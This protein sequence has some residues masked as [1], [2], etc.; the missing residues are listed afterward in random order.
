MRVHVEGGGAVELP[1]ESFVAAGGEA[2]VYAVGDVAYKV[3]TRPTDEAR[4]RALLRLKVASA[5]LPLALLRDEH[6]AVIG[7]T[8][9]FVT[10]GTPLSRALSRTWRERSGL[11]PDEA[12]DV[13][14]Q[15]RDAVQ[16]VHRAGALVVD[17]HEGNVVL[18]P[19]RSPLLLDTSSWQL[20][21][22]PATAIQDAVRDRHATAFDRGTDWFA[23]AVTTLHLLLGIHPYRGTHPTVK[24]L[25]ARMVHRLSVLRPEVK[26]P[27]VCFPL[28]V[29]P[30]PWRSWY[31]SVLDGP[32]RTPPPSGGID[33]VGWFPTVV[34]TRGQLVLT[35]VLEAPGPILTALE[36]EGTTVAHQADGVNVGST[37]HAGRYEAVGIAADG[38]VLGARRSAGPLSVWVVATGRELPTTLRADAVAPFGPGLLVTS[39]P[40]LLQLELRAGVLVPRLLSAVLPHATAVFGSVAVQDLLGAAHLLL[41]APGRCDVRRVPEL[42]G[43]KMLDAHHARGVVALHARKDGRTDRFVFRFGPSAHDLRRT[44]DVEGADLDLVALPSGVA[45]LRV[46]GRLELF[47]AGPGDDDLRLIEDPA[48]VGTRLLTL[49]GQLGLVSGTRVLRATLV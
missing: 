12:L 9:R 15:L 46:D 45:V 41:L 7:H 39:G 25:D 44:A 35:P 4:L 1:P 32:E 47:R 28:D 10:G 42:D 31:A 18:D 29:V 38:T 17:L 16:A 49:G 6:G 8:M 43:W 27:P 40:R 21:G 26:R 3:M 2:T 36:R 22:F 14:R 37:F 34:V 30:P 19:D 23:F 13:V 11:G 20:P 5:V 33:G 48:L 24:G